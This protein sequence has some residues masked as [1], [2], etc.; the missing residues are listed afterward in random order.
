M[1]NIVLTRI[2]DRL[3]HGQIAVK[4]LSTIDANTIVIV[5]DR[6]K[7]DRLMSALLR[8]FCPKEYKLHIFTENEAIQYL[9]E[10]SDLEKIFLLTKNPKPI[11]NLIENGIT[12]DEVFVGNMGSAPGRNNIS[13]SIAV[14]NDE[15]ECFMRIVDAGVK[16][17]DQMLP[18][19][20]KIKIEDL[21]NIK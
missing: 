8:S 19:D 4:W 15:I 12:F 18:S 6:V 5:D 16:V 17:Y 20:E 2:D 3:I 1:K 10:D 9:K 7:S 21:I 13:K 11:M 14:D